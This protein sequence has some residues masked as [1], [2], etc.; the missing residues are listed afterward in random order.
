MKLNSDTING[1][2]LGSTYQNLV[3]AGVEFTKKSI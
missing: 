2:N 3:E 1:E